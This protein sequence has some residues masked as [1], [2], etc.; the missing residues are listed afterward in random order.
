VGRAG[1]SYRW[2]F[3]GTTYN[4]GAYNSGTVFKITP[5]GTL[6]TLYSFCRQ[7]NCTDGSY[8][9]AGL[10]QATDGS[11]CGTTGHGG[12][13]T[14]CS[15]DYGCGTVFKISA[16][17][18]LTLLYSF[19]GGPSSGQEP[20]GGLIQARDGNF[21]GT[22]AGGGNSTN[23][24]NGY[25]CGTVF[26]ITPEGNL[27]YLHDFDF[28]D[29]AQPEAGLVQATDGSLYGTTEQGAGGYGP[30][31]GRGCGTV[32]KITT[33]G[34]FTTPYAFCSQAGCPDGAD[35]IAGPV[36]ATDGNFY[37]TTT[38]G[39]NDSGCGGLGCGI[40][41]KVTAT[42][43]LTTL[44]SF[45]IQSDC[46]D[47]QWPY[48]R[49]LQAT[50][51]DLSGTTY[52][53]GV[54]DNCSDG[55]GNGCGTLFSLSVGLEPFVETN[56]T[57]GK[58]GTAVIILGTNL[59]GSTRVTFHGTAAKFTVVSKTEIKTMVPKGATT[60]KVNVKTPKGTLVSNLEFRV[61]K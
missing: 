30:C 33:E 6:T 4:G 39:G 28:S 7:T 9:L 36:Q 18:E 32:F 10:V 12:D 25:S 50:N 58:V 61:T 21:Y 3:Y 26:K 45:C 41:F 60:G 53:G 38:Y 31:F 54:S 15:G 37:G 51:G 24:Y 13:P 11:F 14:T 46:A 29:G 47:G 2:D 17:G 56:P 48:G 49:L 1:A 5:T 23:C 20:M 22:T 57:S 55:Y 16:R 27:T 8:P 42:G 35:P 43:K 52:Y 34:E 40:I 44:Y 19:T 59:K